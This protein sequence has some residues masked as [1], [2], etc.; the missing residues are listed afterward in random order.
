MRLCVSSPSWR[1]P[2]T[3]AAPRAPPTRAAAASRAAGAEMRWWMRPRSGGPRAARASRRAALVEE[4]RVHATVVGELRVERDR[5]QRALAR[6]DRVAV[7]RGEDLDRRAVL[8]D[9]GGA[10][11]HRPDGTA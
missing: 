4:R 2:G 8:G 5:E 3:A 1:P 11:E 9:P 6:G 7:A 10:D